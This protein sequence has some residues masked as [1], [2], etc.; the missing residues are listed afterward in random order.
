MPTVPLKDWIYCGLIVLLILGGFWYHHKILAEGIAKQQIADDRAS[1]ILT[2]QTIKRTTELQI[3][4]TTAEQAYDK[5][6]ADGQAYRDSIKQR[7]IRLCLDSHPSGGLVPQAG[8]TLPG[9]VDPR[10]GAQHIPD[11]PPGDSSD[12]AGTADSTIAA[13]LLLLAD[14]GDQVSAELREFQSR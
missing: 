11:L 2:A 6:I 5:E 7:P 8:A 10:T 12:R 13:L 4:A 1:A 3:R 9:N 14:R